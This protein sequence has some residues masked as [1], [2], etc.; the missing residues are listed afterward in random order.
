MWTACVVALALGVQPAQTGALTLNQPRFTFGPAGLTRTDG[1]FLPGDVVYMT[2]DVAGLKFD[3]ESKAKYSVAMEISDAAGN[4]LYRQKPH[5]SMVRNVLGG[6]AVPCSVQVQLPVDHPAGTLTVKVTV[7]DKATNQSGSVSKKVEVLKA[8]FGIVQLYTTAGNAGAVPVP[9]VGA[10]GSL[11][12]V[13]F[14]AVGFARGKDKQPDLSGTLR[15]LDEGGKETSAKPFTGRLNKDVAPDAM[16]VPLQFGVTL[17]RAGRFT[18]EL[19]ATDH[20]SGQKSTVSMPL[21][22]VGH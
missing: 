4:T 5:A 1:K 21:K 3:D 12:Y 22:V 7:E 17:N 14:V 13:H 19:T 9:S 20:I 15:V 10:E 2:F 11:L 18:L 8:G 6:K 16:V